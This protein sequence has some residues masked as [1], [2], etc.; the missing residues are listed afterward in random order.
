LT[1]TLSEKGLEFLPSVATIS[2][3][4]YSSFFS[5]DKYDLIR[6]AAPHDVGDLCVKF[7]FVIVNLVGIS[8]ISDVRQ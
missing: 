2:G 1:A 6:V 7:M 4:V 3:S 5:E 8:G